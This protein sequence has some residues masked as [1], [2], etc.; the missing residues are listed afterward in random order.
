M[1]ER[2]SW[3][4]RHEA[5]KAGVQVHALPLPARTAATA[6]LLAKLHAMCCRLA[7]LFHVLIFGPSVTLNDEARAGTGL[8]NALSIATTSLYKYTGYH[9]IN[10]LIGCFAIAALRGPACCAV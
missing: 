9:F 6:K 8:I 3:L 1:C 7:G 5:G 2:W 10:W 4:G